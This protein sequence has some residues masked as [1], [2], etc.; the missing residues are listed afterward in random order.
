MDHIAKVTTQSFYYKH[1]FLS[2]YFTARLVFL[3]ALFMYVCFVS[4]RVCCFWLFSHFGLQ[5]LLLVA[6]QNLRI[7]HRWELRLW[8]CGNV[9]YSCYSRNSSRVRTFRSARSLLIRA[10]ANETERALYEKK[11]T[12]YVF[13]L[14]SRCY[15]L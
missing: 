5:S 8:R 12:F 4:L 7:S 3:V 13:Y 2:C 6:L 11:K 1:I 14:F 10:F 15:E 9:V